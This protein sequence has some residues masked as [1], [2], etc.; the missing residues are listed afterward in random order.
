MRLSS[1]LALFALPLALIACGPKTPQPTPFLLVEASID[2]LHKAL[3]R[4]ETTCKA[5]VRGELARI[6]AYDKARDLNAIIMI[7]DNALNRAEAMDAARI[8]GEKL[9]PLYCV[10]VVVKDNFDTYDFPTTGGSIALKDSTPPDDAFMVRKLREADAIIIA[11]TNMAEWAFS[12]RETISS[13]F[14]TTANAYAR[15]RVPAGSSGGTASAVAASFAIAGLGSDTGNS[16]RGPSSH[17]ALVGIRSTMGLTSRDGVIPLIADR[18]IAGPMT[19][20]VRDTAIMFNVVAGYDPADPITAEGKNKKADDYTKFLDKDGLKGARLGV[21]RKFVNTKDADPQVIAIFEQALRDLAAAGAIIIDPFTV[22]DMQSHIDAENTCPSFRYDMTKYLK[23]L[24][25]AAPFKD[26][27]WVLENGL[28]GPDAQGGL[29]YFAPFPADRAPEDW[30]EPCLRYL[31]NPLRASYRQ[32]VLD[33]MNEHHLDA[34]IY[35]S[36]SNPPAH[37]DKG[38][39][40]YKGDNSQSLAPSTGMPAITVPMGYSYGKLPA[41]LQ[42]VA[43]PY[44][45]GT[46]FKLAYA[47]EQATHHRRPPDGFDE[48]AR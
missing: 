2:G 35:P 18:D 26:V 15:G 16:I 27:N 19:R 29:E 3:E 22:K 39:E 6:A 20:S 4:R 41:G 1:S 44:A 34:L 45:E 24:G 48:L 37:L 17:L 11:K 47:Y 38:R 9:G 5:V 8:T 40:E 14:G 31:D 43:R 10:P 23:T 25:D 46:L 33:A 7:N 28:Y 32:D 21:L 12:P 36:W 30:D 13:S 42:M